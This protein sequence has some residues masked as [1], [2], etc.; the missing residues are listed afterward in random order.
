MNFGAFC[1]LKYIQS[2]NFFHHLNSDKIDPIQI[3]IFLY[4]SSFCWLK[5]V[6]HQEK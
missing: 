2:V 3:A 5:M 1:V 6:L 4:L